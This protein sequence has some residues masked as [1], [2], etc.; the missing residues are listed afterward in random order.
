MKKKGGA[1]PGAGR[2]KGVP[3]RISRELIEEAKAT[4]DLPHE[5]LLKIAQNKLG[6]KVILGYDMFGK[7]IRGEPDI[8]L[9]QRAAEAAAPYY[10]PRL[11]Q[12]EAKIGQTAIHYMICDK[13]LG[14]ESFDDKYGVCVET[15][16]E[17]EDPSRLPVSGDLVRGESRRGE[18]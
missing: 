6:K 12:I 17:T 5:F 14:I 18:N 10:A 7:A 4:G 9:R 1:R 11:A 8:K 3:N 15:T 2:P 16:A 13:P